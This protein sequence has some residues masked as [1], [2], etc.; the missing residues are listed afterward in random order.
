M[1]YK[2]IIDL[3]SSV[4]STVP[5]QLFS[6]VY[7]SYTT[8]LERKTYKLDFQFVS[9]SESWN[10]SIYDEDEEPLLMNQALVPSYP[11]DPPISSGLEGFFILVPV[12]DNS[13]G[14][15]DDLK[16]NLQDNYYFAYITKTEL[17]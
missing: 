4:I 5:L 6:D 12:A 2:T 16:W 10:M 13:N 15:W 3:D 7:Y 11:I 14:K 9:F 17:L 8:I 1:S